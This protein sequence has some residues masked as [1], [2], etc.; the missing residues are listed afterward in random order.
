MSEKKEK[1]KAKPVKHERPAAYVIH[2]P[3]AADRIRANER[4]DSPA[5]NVR[6]S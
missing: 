1:R 6:V 3:D 2:R 4:N 5:L